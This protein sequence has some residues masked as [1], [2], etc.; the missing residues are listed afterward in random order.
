L[1]CGCKTDSLFYYH[2]VTR[3]IS[4]KMGN[5]KSKKNKI[6]EKK[7]PNNATDIQDNAAAS[8]KDSSLN[9]EST[10]VTQ[11]KGSA[12]TKTNT[13]KENRS[14][15]MHPIHELIWNSESHDV[16]GRGCD[17]CQC[18]FGEGSK[19]WQCSICGFDLC[20]EC[21]ERE[22]VELDMKTFSRA[23]PLH[24]VSLLFL[25]YA[26]SAG[27]LDPALTMYE[28]CEQHVK[29][30][31]F[32][33]KTSYAEHLLKSSLHQEMIAKG[34]TGIVKPKADIFISYTWS[35][36]WGE[37]M[38]IL[39]QL[40][41][42]T[43][44]W[45][46]VLCVNQHAS[47]FV[48][49]EGWLETFGGAIKAIGKAGLVINPFDKP[50]GITRSWCCFE[51]ASVVREGVDMVPLLSPSEGTEKYEVGLE[52]DMFDADFF[53]KLFT[54]VN[55]DEA[56]A[57]N[58]LDRVEIQ[59][60]IRK[61]GV[62]S[63]NDAVMVPLKNALKNG[64]DRVLEINFKR[65]Q[66][67]ESDLEDEK[68]ANLILGNV[69]NSLGG[70]YR[71]LG[72]L[73]TACKFF[74]NAYGVREKYLTLEHPLTLRSMSNY[75]NACVFAGRIEVALPIL[76]TV[77]RVYREFVDEDD[78]LISETDYDLG[79]AYYKNNQLL[80]SRIAF[81]HSRKIYTRLVNQGHP[82][83]QEWIDAINKMLQPIA[84]ALRTGCPDGC[85][86]SLHVPFK[87]KESVEGISVMVMGD[88]KKSEPMFERFV[89]E[90]VEQC[91]LCLR[92]LEISSNVTSCRKC[93]YVVCEH[94]EKDD[95]FDDA[96]FDQNH[97]ELSHDDMNHA[98]YLQRIA[99]AQVQ[100]NNSIAAL[101]SLEKAYQISRRING[102]R[103]YDTLTLLEKKYK[104]AKA[105]G[106]SQ[107]ASKLA[108]HIA[109]VL[110]EGPNLD[111]TIAL[112]VA[113]TISPAVKDLETAQKLAKS[114]YESAVRMFGEDNKQAKALKESVTYFCER[115][116][117][118][119]TGLVWDFKGPESHRVGQATRLF[120]NLMGDKVGAKL[121]TNFFSFVGFDDGSINLVFDSEADAIESMK[122]YKGGGDTGGGIILREVGVHGMDGI[123]PN[124]QVNFVV[125]TQRRG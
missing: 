13:K 108:Q 37:L 3:E 9:V 94:C 110:L 32:F 88:G 70:L 118:T 24:G 52:K 10:L 54:N 15:P 124:A 78:N 99:D 80:K 100:A 90:E 93:K 113:Q 44:I 59:K 75:G 4:S 20:E 98:F 72:D 42:E 97:E 96:N 77:R 105:T 71:A 30:N 33:F 104:L 95:P 115:I 58:E 63:V 85:T 34:E 1:R 40:S 51:Y 66:E 61:M 101:A 81:I 125:V 35:L 38:E 84:N 26:T 102:D 89:L 22:P 55:V 57:Q 12:A 21:I 119:L 107:E 67:A 8:L 53:R 31:T 79:I 41:M 92:Q 86:R 109:M 5:S 82:Q 46:D 23:V 25:D 39:S 76:E 65:V 69:F 28:L 91:S 114:A 56:S 103:H 49:C 36:R 64:G 123:S 27:Q 73:E 47:S 6:K 48:D 60:I 17:G 29:K 121:S 111:S 43:F 112:G 87:E 74:N 106:Q 2:I 68:S 16:Q 50:V 19:P 122:E 62:V 83:F 14:H 11:K 120:K 45:L 117:V 7:L 116:T 18:Q